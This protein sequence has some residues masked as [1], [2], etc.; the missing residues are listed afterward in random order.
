MKKGKGGTSE[1]GQEREERR[2]A[3]EAREERR[4]VGKKRLINT[5]AMTGVAAAITDTIS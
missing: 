4:R 5:F 1:E 2:R 3:G